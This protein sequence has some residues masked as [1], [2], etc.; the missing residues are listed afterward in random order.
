MTHKQALEVISQKRKTVI[1]LLRECAK[2]EEK[3]QIARTALETL[4]TD[5]GNQ[6]VIVR[7]ALERII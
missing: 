2:Y 1:F 7:N 5:C 6:K 3:L 4:R